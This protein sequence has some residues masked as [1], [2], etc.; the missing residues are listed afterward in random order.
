MRM[1][2]ATGLGAT[3]VAM[4]LLLVGIG[5][6]YAAAQ[7]RAGQEDRP[8][9][10]SRAMIAAGIAGAALIAT[11]LVWITRPGYSEVEERVA[12]LIGE[13]GDEAP[14]SAD[15]PGATAGDGTVI[16]TLDT[17][18]SRIT[19]ARTDDI[20]FEWAANGCVNER[21]QYGMVG[22]EWTR[23]FVPST[24]AAVSVNTYDPES[25]TL[26]TDRYLLGRSAMEAARAARS[27]YDPPA[28]GVTDAARLVGEQQSALLALLPDR[29]NERLVYTCE[30][31]V[32]GVIGGDE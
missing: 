26:R 25:R 32:S 17:E 14:G 5:S 16:C 3:L 19:G 22:G 30:T 20:E 28:C 8:E 15:T 12:A 11:V 27:E 21:T 1:R 13:D 2:F 9:Y 31:K 24:E 18:R 23:V 10:R 7:L 4:V 6:G 29:P